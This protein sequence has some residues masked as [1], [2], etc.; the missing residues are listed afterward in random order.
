MVFKRVK[1]KY[2]KVLSAF[3]MFGLKMRFEIPFSSVVEKISSSVSRV[4][5]NVSKLSFAP[6][7]SY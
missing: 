3:M 1:R 7:R 6:L 4:I 5:K 2:T